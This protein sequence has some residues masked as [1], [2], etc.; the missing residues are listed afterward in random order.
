MIDLI[1]RRIESYFIC[2]RSSCK[3]KI[4]LKD[5]YVIKFKWDNEENRYI[6]KVIC[7][8]CLCYP[9]SFNRF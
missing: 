4:H 3:R 2:S 7:G 9:I 1:L 5:N 8:K 6:I